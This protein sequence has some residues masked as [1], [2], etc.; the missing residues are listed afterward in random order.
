MTKERL[1][2]SRIII[3]EKFVS[4]IRKRIVGYEEEV[5]QIIICLFS[6]GPELRTHVLLEGVPGVAK[7]ELA[8]TIAKIIG[9]KFNRIQGTPDL[10]PSDIVGVEIWNSKKE[11]FETKKGPVFTNILLVDEI[12][13]A[14]PKTQS[15][16]LEAMQEGGVT[17]GDVTYKLSDL[18]ML[19]DLF[20]VLATQNP[21]E[22]E[23]VFPLPEAQIDRFMMKIRMGYVSR[24]AERTIV[25]WGNEA[26]PEIKKILEAEQVLEI[27]SLIRKGVKISDRQKDYIV[28]LV[29][30]TRPETSSLT[31]VQEA[32]LLGASPRAE[33]AIEAA[34]RVHAFLR[35]RMNGEYVVLPDDIDEVALPILRHRIIVNPM[36]V[37]EG[38]KIADFVDELISKTIVD[39][40]GKGYR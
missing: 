25:D 34:S 23:G 28:D 27:R 2:D 7:T 12:N 13:R 16:L 15:A 11:E 19:S 10:L 33:I 29:R 22:H 21:I 32:V 20:M 35:G 9:S 18:S 38:E 31:E 30:A 4:E 39:K 24:E 5:R 40:I 37:P 26:R 8:K 36:A 17:I 6:A 1:D 14:T 3:N